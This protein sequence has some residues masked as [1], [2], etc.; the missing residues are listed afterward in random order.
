MSENH[1]FVFAKI[2]PKSEHFEE[3]KRA[4]LNILEPTREESGCFHFQL[5]ENMSEGVL[6]LYEEWLNESALEAHYQT[7]YTMAVFESYQQ[8]LAAPVEIH[9][10]E[11]CII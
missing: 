3:A 8:W 2:S 5:H 4:I 9:K 1:L 6:Y 10:M 7:P 11:K